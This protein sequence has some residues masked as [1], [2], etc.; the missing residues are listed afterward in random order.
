MGATPQPQKLGC[1]EVI[2]G[3]EGHPLCSHQ[4]LE[5]SYVF[6]LGF[7]KMFGSE[8]RLVFSIWLPLDEEYNLDS[9][10]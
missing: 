4:C 7:S 2:C 3:E 1:D 10:P 8:F 5:N 6:D 9:C